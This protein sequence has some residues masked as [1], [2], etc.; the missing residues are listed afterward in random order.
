[1]SRPVSLAD[2]GATPKAMHIKATPAECQALAQRFQLVHLDHLEAEVKI[3]R[4][5]HRIW[6]EGQMEAKGAQACVVSGVPVAFLVREAIK[7]RFVDQDKDSTQAEEIELESDAL[8]EL[9]IEGGRI[10]AGEA[11]AQSLVLA[12]D[13]Y[14]RAEDAQLA[15][16][17]RHLMS[18][19][20]AARREAA[21]KAAA[22]PF[23]ALQKPKGE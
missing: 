11:V 5:D 1:M 4:A 13:P 2:I 22:N 16:V 14:P 6:L 23:A 19:E 15:P 18:E 10:D 9:P 3:Y 12:L 17:R 20:E 21:E 8:D 7:L